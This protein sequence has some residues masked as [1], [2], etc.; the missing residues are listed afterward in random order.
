[1]ILSNEKTY[2]E[3]IKKFGGIIDFNYRFVRWKLPNAK[4]YALYLLLHEIGHLIFSENYTDEKLQ[5]DSSKTEEQW[6]DKYAM[7]KLQEILLV[8][9]Y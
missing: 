9:P 4:R 2:I 1:M 3:Q 8:E 5:G 6:C 7:G